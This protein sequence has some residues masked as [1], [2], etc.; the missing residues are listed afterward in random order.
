MCLFAAAGQFISTVVIRSGFK[1]IRKYEEL[2]PFICAKLRICC[3][4]ELPSFF[5]RCKLIASCADMLSAIFG[6]AKLCKKVS[7]SCL[8][9][10]QDNLVTCLLSNANL[11][12]KQKQI[13]NFSDVVTEMRTSIIKALLHLTT[14]DKTRKLFEVDAEKIY[15]ILLE[16][17]LKNRFETEATQQIALISLTNL[18]TS[19]NGKATIC[20]L[21]SKAIDDRDLLPKLVK[22]YNAQ[23]STFLSCLVSKSIVDLNHEHI[24]KIWAKFKLVA[25][26]MRKGFIPKSSFQNG[27]S[28]ADPEDAKS[29]ST[30]ATN[31]LK[32]TIISVRHVVWSRN[33]DDATI[34]MDLLPTPR[35]NSRGQIDSQSICQPPENPSK[36]TP[37][38]FAY[39][40]SIFCANLLKLLIQYLDAQ[41]DHHRFIYYEGGVERLVSLLANSDQ[42]HETVTKN[43]ATALARLVKN[44]DKAMHRCRELRGMEILLEL[45]QSGRI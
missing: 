41:P 11:S 12:N 34:I 7:L 4:N 19:I 5:E 32:L 16:V 45:G 1:Q 31:I 44:S 6:D 27:T 10:D 39:R 17:A 43:A 3:D 35:T 28:A 13:R 33:D 21:I 22:S 24:N 25:K 29:T 8:K 15:G 30:L 26:I 20:D 23:S 40:T 9:S 36:D 18:V 38:A 37:I 2:L 14:V 42:Y